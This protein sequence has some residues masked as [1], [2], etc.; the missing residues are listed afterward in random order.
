MHLDETTCQKNLL[1]KQQSSSLKKP[2]NFSGDKIALHVYPHIDQHK[3][4]R[5]YNK[6]VK[7][8]YMGERKR[9]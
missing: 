9:R 2:H 5:Q 7:K 8:L 3:G 1:N 6:M 4:W